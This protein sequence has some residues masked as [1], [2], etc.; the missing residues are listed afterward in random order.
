MI[1][2][3]MSLAVPAQA[4]SLFDV[5][6]SAGLQDVSVTERSFPNAGIGFQF[7]KQAFGPL[8]GV[9]GLQGDLTVLSDDASAGGS[10]VLE[11]VATMR[12]SLGARLMVGKKIS[13]FVE[14]RLQLPI[15]RS[16][17]VDTGSLQESF[18]EWH[19]GIGL[20]GGAGLS[21][22]LGEHVHLGVRADADWAGGIK[23][24]IDPN[25]PT[26]AGQQVASQL[27]GWRGGLFL[28]LR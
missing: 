4:G 11:R 25:D 3:L 9:I 26:P 2:L 19:A 22:G 21:V 17:G 15:I 28:S 1:P 27:S 8:Y 23:N 18:A 16:W 10:K 14:G 6:V 7:G 20:G 12:P 24:P 5:T 13:P